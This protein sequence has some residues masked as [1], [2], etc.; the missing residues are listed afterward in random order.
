[1]TDHR[2]VAPR[3][4]V[5]TAY[6]DGGFRFG[7]TRVEGAVLILDGIVEALPLGDEGEVTSH[8]VARLL[9]ADMVPEFL[10]LGGGE[11]APAPAPALMKAL[12][13]AR[14]GYEPMATPAACR[15]YTAIRE[16]GRS[17]ATALIPV[18]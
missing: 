10:L 6:G 5:L 1:M 9:A 15:V 4:P 16:E 7:D 18:D 8:L 3:H 12:T 14:I 11:T 2:P 17:F 13:E